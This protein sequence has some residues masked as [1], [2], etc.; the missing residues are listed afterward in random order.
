MK[1][2]T[3]VAQVEKTKLIQHFFCWI[4]INWFSICHAIKVS[5]HLVNKDTRPK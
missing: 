1:N 3:A 2:K 5:L 4:K